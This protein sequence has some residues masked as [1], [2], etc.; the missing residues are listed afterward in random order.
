M[1]TLDQYNAE[2]RAQREAFRKMVERP[3]DVACNSC[4]GMMVF[5]EPK[6]YTREDAKRVRCQK[7]GKGGL[8][9]VRS[10]L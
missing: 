9:E 7:C 2:V 5:E 6:S 3:A 4:G 10:V 8:M 1:K